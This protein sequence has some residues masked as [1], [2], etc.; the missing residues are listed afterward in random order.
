MENARQDLEN[1]KYFDKSKKELKSEED[2]DMNDILNEPTVS[3]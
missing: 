3:E 1:G 2:A